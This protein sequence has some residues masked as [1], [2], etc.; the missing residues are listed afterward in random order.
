MSESK[1]GPPP[2][3]LH[4]SPDALIVDDRYQRTMITAASRRLVA[5]IVDEFNWIY[6][7]ILLVTDNG[8]GTYCTID[9]Q[10]RAEAARRHPEVTTVPCMVLE[11]LSLVDQA[12]AFVAINQGRIKLNGLQLH[13][14]AVLAHDPHAVT[15]SEIAKECGIHI[16]G[17]NIP[18]SMMKPGQTLAISTLSKILIKYKPAGLRLTL[19]TVMQAYGDTVGDLRSQIFTAVAIA[20]HKFPNHVTHIAN[21]LADADAESWQVRGREVGRATGKT[22]VEAIATLL[23]KDL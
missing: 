21:I 11:E 12:K 16:P 19:H 8:D 17:N 9:G 15:L 2:K 14:A 22:T 1:L 5:K 20:V 7:G 6:F 18:A 3:I 10:H 13:K 23:T 4:L